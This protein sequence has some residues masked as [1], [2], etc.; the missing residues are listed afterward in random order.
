MVVR[1]SQSVHPAIAGAT[2]DINQDDPVVWLTDEKG[3]DRAML[4]IDGLFFANAKARPTLSLGSDPKSGM[5]ALK[6]YA[7]DGKVSWSAP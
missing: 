7:A 4:T 2:M 3:A 5:S 1:E 6:F